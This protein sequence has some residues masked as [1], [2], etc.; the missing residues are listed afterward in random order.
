MEENNIIQPQNSY[1][2]PVAI[3][4]AGAMI[5]GAVI[6]SNRSNTPAAGGTAAVGNSGAVI[7]D[8]NIILGNA[9]ILGNPKAPLTLVEFGDFQC[10][11][12]GRFFETTEKDLIEKY[13]KTG[14]AKFAFRN[15]AFLG[16]ESQWAAVAAECAKEQGKF[17]EYHDYLYSHQAGENRGAFSKDNLKQFASILGFNK[18]EFNFCLDSDKYFKEV[19]KDTEDGK[20]FGVSGT[21]TTFV[22]GKKV[23]GAVSIS[24]FEAAIKDI[25]KK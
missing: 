18:T 21:P 1:A 11:F 22:N 12:C 15:F 17:W 23:V 4:I 5:A 8:E 7:Q 16:P 25:L 2:I 13:V 6:F 3:V 20:Q 24:E 10:P 9:P 19:Q 14:K